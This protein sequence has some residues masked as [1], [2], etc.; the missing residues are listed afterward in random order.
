[1]PRRPACPFRRARLAVAV[2]AVRDASH[3]FAREHNGPGRDAA[4]DA[5]AEAMVHALAV[6]LGPSAGASAALL[7]ASLQHHADAGGP[8]RN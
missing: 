4:L 7:F 6:G 1:M 5:L 3:A 8:C 2:E